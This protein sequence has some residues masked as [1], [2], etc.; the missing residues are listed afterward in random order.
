MA[1]IS[2]YYIA[3]LVAVLLVVYYRPNFKARKALSRIPTHT[4]DDA[5]DRLLQG[6]EDHLIQSGYDK[7]SKINEVFKIKDRTG[8][9]RI[10]LPQQK[11]DEIKNLSAR[12]FSFRA[13]VRERMHM[14]YSWAIYGA[15][16]AAKTVRHDVNRNLA[17]VVDGMTTVIEAYFINT[18]PSSTQD[19]DSVEILSLLD[20]CIARVAS[21]ILFG[22]AF[23]NDPEWVEVA[24]RVTS[25]AGM[26]ASDIRAYP[27]CTRRWA[28]YFI[29]S[30]KRIKRDKAVA[31]RK[32]GPLFHQRMAERNDSSLKKSDD[33]LQWLLDNAGPNI[34]LAEFIDNMMRLMLATIGTITLTATVALIDLLS[35]PQYIAELTQEIHEVLNGSEIRIEDLEKLCKLDSFLSE[36]QRLTPTLKGKFYLLLAVR[37]ASP[38]RLRPFH[39]FIAILTGK[40]ANLGQSSIAKPFKT[41]HSATVS[42]SPQEPRYTLPFTQ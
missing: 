37:A 24:R 36:S 19:W 6:D 7:Y 41:T 39:S 35:Q 2:V 8:K 11:L 10:I 3:C 29:G 9:F 30:F 26:A 32:L 40:P 22:P 18:L 42:I 16:W 20:P 4:I 15:P 14:Q 31:V 12:L 38:K 27:T 28:T 17:Q 1:G 21:Q 33:P 25:N 23:A 13:W 34:T 5:E